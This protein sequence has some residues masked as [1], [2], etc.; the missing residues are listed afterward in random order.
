MET[1]FKLW[2]GNNNTYF[3]YY[4]HTHKYFSGKRK[5]ISSKILCYKYLTPNS[6]YESGRK[7]GNEGEKEG[8]REG[9]VKLKDESISAVD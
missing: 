3:S 6:P 2:L 5:R 7:G 8:G 1:I 9:N 4:A